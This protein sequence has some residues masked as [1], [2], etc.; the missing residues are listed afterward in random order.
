MTIVTELVI[1]PGVVDK[2][3]QAGRNVDRKM[4]EAHKKIQY[5]IK[6]HH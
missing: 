1:T 2:V 6:G 3:K 4:M 5:R